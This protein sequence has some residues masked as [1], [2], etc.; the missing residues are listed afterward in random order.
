MRESDRHTDFLH[1][2][3]Q[4]FSDGVTAHRAQSD[5]QSRT[6]GVRV[7]PR[8][9]FELDLTR[10]ASGAAPRASKC[11]PVQQRKTRLLHSRH[12]SLYSLQLCDSEGSQPAPFVA[13]LRG[14]T[15]ARI[16]MQ[17]GATT[18]NASVARVAELIAF[19]DVTFE[20]TRIARAVCCAHARAPTAAPPG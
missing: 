13:R 9:P 18:K 20:T 14:G 6:V 10:I 16:K 12:N 5:T 1:E 4:C 15:T 3:S 7:A 2:L 8:A 19:N 11:N 17:R